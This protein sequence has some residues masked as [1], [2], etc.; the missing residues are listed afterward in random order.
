MII[1][2]IQEAVKGVQVMARDYCA[3]GWKPMDEVS[4]AVIDNMEQIELSPSSP[5]PSRAI[6][7]AIYKPVSVEEATGYSLDPREPTPHGRADKPS[8]TRF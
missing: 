8:S 5:H 6:P 1:R 2:R 7:K 4:V 3:I